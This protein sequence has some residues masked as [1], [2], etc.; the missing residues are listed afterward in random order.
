MLKRSE[1]M[2]DMMNQG[3]ANMNMSMEQIEIERW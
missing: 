2:L 1:A 3:T